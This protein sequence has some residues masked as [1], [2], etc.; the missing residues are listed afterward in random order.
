[1]KRLGGKETV[2][3]AEKK[4]AVPGDWNPLRSAEQADNRQKMLSKA[5]GLKSEACPP[6]LPQMDSA[7]TET[8]GQDSV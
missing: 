8:W 6:Q 1:M 4:D 3:A 2:I 5:A 7:N